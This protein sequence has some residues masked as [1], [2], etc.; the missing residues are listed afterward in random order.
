[1]TLNTKSYKS[2]LPKK[3]TALSK[4]VVVG[5]FVFLDTALS[6]LIIASNWSFSSIFFFFTEIFP[7]T[8]ALTGFYL[9]KN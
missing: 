3:P 9:Y 2:Q 5:D 4:H 6:K 1:M 8:V 7:K